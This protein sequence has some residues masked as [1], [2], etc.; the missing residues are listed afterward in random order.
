MLLPAVLNLINPL[1]KETYIDSIL[2]CNEKTWECGLIL[3]EEEA[4]TII[5]VRNNVLNSYGRV[6]LGMDAALGLIESFHTSSFIT[7]ENYVTTLNELQEIF[8]HMK[9]E[10]ED[11]IPD[12]KL[13]D[14]IKYYYE[15]SCG[16][17]IELLKS[18]LEVFTEDFRRK[19]QK[20]GSLGE[21]EE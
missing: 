8:Y 7:C 16:G 17:S 13:I 21:G 14:T 11:M 10:T 9:N 18:S 19:M 5:E 1:L 2:K 15:N 12:D 20:I 4:K 6:D 3:T